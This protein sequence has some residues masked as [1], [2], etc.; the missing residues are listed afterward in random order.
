MPDNILLCMDLDRTALPN[1]AQPESPSA[2]DRLRQ[3]ANR[4]E[5]ILAYVSG[6]RRELQVEAIDEYSLPAPAFAVADVGTS[7]YAVQD[8]SW[9]VMADWQR[10]I[11]RSW[12]DRTAEALQP[13][14]PELPELRLQEP[15]AQGPYKLSYFAPPDLDAEEVIEQLGA[16]LESEGFHSSVIWSVDETTGTGLL[17]I[18]PERATK[19]HAVEFLMQ[20]LGIEVSR[21]VY[22]GDSGNDLPVL[23]SGLQAVLVANA[24]SE[25][26][27]Q[28]V[29][30]A[31]KRGSPDRLYLA[32]GGFLGMNG[33]YAAGILEGLAHFIPETKTWMEL[34]PA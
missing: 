17:D 31:A 19:L 27:R 2:R 10:D 33:N 16:R 14:V 24:T 7:I 4:P 6:R 20:H 3:L 21:M 23:S 13:L 29:A 15:E 11:G 1:G 26:R 22:A 30:A 12:G 32:R 28:S 18:L 8:G 5:V 34:T 9:G 25:V